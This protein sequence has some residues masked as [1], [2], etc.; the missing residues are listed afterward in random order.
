M[1]TN[2]TTAVDVHA[3][4]LRAVHQEFLDY[5]L[6]LQ[7]QQ[8]QQQCPPFVQSSAGAFP[9]LRY[10]DVGGGR[11]VVVRALVMFDDLIVNATATSPRA[12]DDLDGEVR[13]RLKLSM[14]TWSPFFSSGGAGGGEPAL[15]AAGEAAGDREGSKHRQKQRDQ[16]V[17]IF[18]ILQSAVWV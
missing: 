13:R 16:Q 8:Q 12:E 9:A 17:T 4:V 2:T 15:A 18:F 10:A 14:E 6:V 7:Q 3:R 1:V 5:G 11:V